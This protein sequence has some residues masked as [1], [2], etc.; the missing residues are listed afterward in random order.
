MLL[1]TLFEQP[2]RLVFVAEARINR[3][4]FI[5]IDISVPFIAWLTSLGERR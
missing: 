2:E 1:V 3:R 4:N 5:E